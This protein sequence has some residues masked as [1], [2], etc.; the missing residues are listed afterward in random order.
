MNITMKNGSMTINGKSYSGKN[1]CI[2]GNKIVIDGK[3]QEGE[4]V[5]DIN[6]TVNGDVESLSTVSGD[7]TTTGDIGSVKTTS[8][9]VTLKKGDIKTNVQ[10]I[11]GYVT[12]KNIGGG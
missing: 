10:T 1:I 12:A 5:G 3:E 2:D 6:V 8:G 11:S 7:V 4:L 9:D